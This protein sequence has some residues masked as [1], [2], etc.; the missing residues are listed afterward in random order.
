VAQGASPVI[1]V[2]VPIFDVQVN[3]LHAWLEMLSRDGL[4]HNVIRAVIKQLLLKVECNAL[5]I[6]G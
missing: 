3:T 5:K 1:T 6:G 4:K 2:A